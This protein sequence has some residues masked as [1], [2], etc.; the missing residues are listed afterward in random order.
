MQVEPL[1]VSKNATCL[2]TPIL[3]EAGAAGSAGLAM[4]LIGS[5]TP[6]SQVLQPGSVY[7]NPR[8]HLE[9]HVISYTQDSTDI[10]TD[11]VL[12]QHPCSAIPTGPT[13]RV[14]DWP[15]GWSQHQDCAVG[16]AALVA[17]I[18]QS[19]PETTDQVMAREAQLQVASSI[20]PSDA[21]CGSGISVL[22][23]VNG[24]TVQMPM[25]KGFADATR[26][27]ESACS[28]KRSAAEMQSGAGVGLETC[29]AGHL[30]GLG[31]CAAGQ[32]L[33]PGANCH[34]CQGEE[35][36]CPEIFG[37]PVGSIG[38]NKITGN[39]HSSSNSPS[40]GAGI[41][42]TDVLGAA[43]HE[44]AKVWVAADGAGL[45]MVSATDDT[46]AEPFCTYPGTSVAA[47]TTAATAIN[48]GSLT[49]NTTDKG[50]AMGPGSC[51]TSGNGADADLSGSSGIGAGSGGGVAVMD[52]LAKELGPIMAR[53]GGVSDTRHAVRLAALVEGEERLGGRLTLLTVIQQSAQEVLR[54]FVQG[55]G[56]RSLER[57]V[58]QFRDEGRHPALVKVIGCL[59]MLPIDLTA[60]KGSSIG[61]TV[62]KLRKHA[63]QGVRS[64]AAELVEQWKGVVDRSVGKGE[65][66]HTVKSKADSSSQDG[67]NKR[68]RKLVDQSGAAT[69]AAAAAGGAGPSSKVY[70]GTGGDGVPMPTTTATSK[71]AVMDDDLFVSESSG[72]PVSGGSSLHPTGQHR[73]LGLTSFITGPKKVH[74]VK[75]ENVVPSR[76]GSLGG[77]HGGSSAVCAAGSGAARTLGA[78]D[79]A[80]ED[81]SGALPSPT[82]PRGDTSGA[83]PEA[84]NGDAAASNPGSPKHGGDGTS[85]SGNS[86]NGTPSLLPLSGGDG[87]SS[88]ASLAASGGG[89]AAPK[90]MTLPRLGTLAGPSN[91][92]VRLGS[93]RDGSLPTSGIARLG[94]AAGIGSG[95]VSG[96][97]GTAAS[98]PAAVAPGGPQSA[99]ARA[100][101]ARARA[102]SPEPAPRKEKKKTVSWA[103]DEA[104]ASYR[105]FKRDDPPQAASSDAI[106]T[107]EDEA[108]AVAGDASAVPGSGGGVGGLLPPPGFQSAARREHASERMA[109][110]AQHQQ[111]EQ[112]RQQELERWAA[113]R[114]TVPWVE[115]PELYLGAVSPQQMPALG[116]DSTEREVQARLRQHTPRIMYYSPSHV[117]ASPSE[118]PPEPEPDFYRVRIIPLN[119]PSGPQL[120]MGG[121]GPGGQP[122]LLPP[123][124]GMIQPGMYG[125]VPPAQQAHPG[126]PLPL[127]YVS[128]LQPGQMPPQLLPG[129]PSA[130]HQPPPPQGPAGQHGKQQGPGASLTL[131]PD[132]V[133][134]LPALINTLAQQ[135]PGPGPQT[136]PQGGLGP[137]QGSSAPGPQ[138]QSGPPPQGVLPPSHQHPH[139]LPHPH[140]RG[141]HGSSVPPPPPQ[142]P[143]PGQPSSSGGPLAGPP[144]APQVR[145]LEF[146]MQPQPPHT[147]MGPAAGPS[148]GRPGGRFEPGP[149][150]TPSMGLGQG[151]GPAGPP[152]PP[153]RKDGQPT[154]MRPRRADEPPGPGPGGIPLG[155]PQHPPPHPHIMG[156]GRGGRH[157]PAQHM[158]SG[159]SQVP[160][161]MGPPGSGAGP[162]S[163]LGGWGPPA[164]P[165][166]PSVAP[167]SNQG[168]PPPGLHGPPSGKVCVYFNTPGGCRNGDNCRFLHVFPQDGGPLYDNGPYPG[169]GRGGM[170]L[171]RPGGGPPPGL[172]GSLRR[173]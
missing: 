100:M 52:T 138:A 166:G 58:I 126:L 135:P 95:S 121:S 91:P 139:I 105:L 155:P 7:H 73:P 144:G 75:L 87:T 86:G 33:L 88:T 131:P 99:H 2:T 154:L 89:S 163:G 90:T 10:D 3:L 35:R 16:G 70:S 24:L 168:M 104:L 96:R 5:A 66:R 30:P 18:P 94:A 44:E 54:L 28:R 93:L 143:Q 59:K 151:Q 57:W 8:A 39:D 140:A 97:T 112:E 101:A 113:M 161:V 133:A 43:P 108:A 117:P 158:Q 38:S 78:V 69:A 9:G 85:A 48:S 153:P 172:P 118:P 120:P 98:L 130:Q 42:A 32:E 132:L 157:A 67:P 150:M 55:T 125:G 159:G 64:A 171:G 148:P 165:G 74:S 160:H 37:A 47:S 27:S 51:A 20:P 31:A 142:Q 111:E 76:A 107:A 65:A 124:P 149:G 123:P 169:P 137:G 122:A 103:G 84:A 106:L 49:Q 77:P 83:L 79:A 147:G 110:I 152:L 45:S 6:I 109:L 63:N 146:G 50:G 29:L 141:P 17:A 129:A 102:P 116:E 23:I 21:S 14:A 22:P 36:P 41:A 34:S 13:G 68:P 40:S 82:S 72:G 71:L 46:P 1:L 12:L 134:S 62:G 162:G 92:T 26:G 164:G 173:R 167:P 15:P 25:E 119:V 80:S 114:P 127:P 61:Q 81:G 60:L 53:C 115:P 170:G 156:P 11:E 145:S 4:D 19:I 136:A 56:L 128:Q